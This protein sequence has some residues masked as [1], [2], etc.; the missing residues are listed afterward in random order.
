MNKDSIDREKFLKIA[1]RFGFEDEIFA[2]PFEKNTKNKD[3]WSKIAV[4]AGRNYVS[5]PICSKSFR[6][7]SLFEVHMLRKHMA[8]EIELY[9]SGA[10]KQD[11]HWFSFLAEYIR[12]IKI[13]QGNEDNHLIADRICFN[14]IEHCYR[15]SHFQNLLIQQTDSEIDFKV[16]KQILMDKSFEIFQTCKEWRELPEIAD[17]WNSLHSI[18]TKTLMVIGL[19]GTLLLFLFRIIEVFDRYDGDYYDVYDNPK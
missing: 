12:G 17:L 13:G 9:S 7:K 8:G 14:Y 11:P 10:Q 15:N 19:L 6:Q 5:C 18:W 4:T 1:R 16:D 3:L 2:T